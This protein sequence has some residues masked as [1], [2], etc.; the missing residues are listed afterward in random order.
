MFS[1]IFLA[2][3]T[4]TSTL[5]IDVWVDKDNA[6]YQ[7]TENL[8]IYF[9]AN[10]DCF[11]AVF[12]I[13]QGGRITRLFPPE[14]DNGWVDAGQVYSLPPE[15]ADYDYVIE[16]PEGTETVIAV[17]SKD[18]LPDLY[19][20]SPG[21]IS[22]SLEIYIEEPEPSTLRIISTPDDSRIYIMEIFSGDEEYAGQTPRTIV[23]RPGE[24]VVTI[25]K[26]GY[27]TLTRRIW[28]DPGERRRVFVK[29]TRY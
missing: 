25:K 22:K 29:L 20:E 13:E 3:L 24:Y 11:V 6:V 17:A 10:Q 26:L 2:F 27:R 8:K 7:P 19:D 5:D 14:G 21:I 28:L 18:R 1:M 23:L 15:S 16:G 4:I 12:N 9:R